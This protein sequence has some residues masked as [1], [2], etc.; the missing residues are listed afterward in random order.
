MEKTNMIT[1]CQWIGSNPRMQPSCCLPSVQGR[2]YC[3]EHLWSVYQKGTNLGRR[4]KDERVAAQVWDLES[5][6]NLA[7]E[8]LEAEG[9][10]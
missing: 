10:F 4:K 5:E 2:S 9:F 1:E 8:E 7:V 6:F 3:E